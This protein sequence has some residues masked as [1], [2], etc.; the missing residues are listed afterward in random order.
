MKKEFFE[1]PEK[2][3][4]HNFYGFDWLEGLTAVPSPLALVTSFKP[5]GKTN[6]CMQ[7]W[8]T[9]TSSSGFYCLF[10]N[11]HKGTH[12]YRTVNETGALAV[13][14]MSDKEYLKC[15]STIS[16]NSWDSD[17]LTAAG[18]TAKKGTKVNAPI[19]EE[20]FLN[21][22]CEYV[23]EKEFF[24]GSD[25][26]VMCTKVVNVHMDEKYFLSDGH[27]RYGETGYLYNIHSP[28]DPEKGCCAETCLGVIQKFKTYDVIQ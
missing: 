22:E 26:V 8:F 21:L 4:E 5:N 17:E 6:G 9:L 27:G 12:M 20:C 3:R 23:W 10:G 16:H 1:V 13:N 2:L 7:S 25:H 11:V 19:V 18:L 28:A 14:F 15:Y 24:P